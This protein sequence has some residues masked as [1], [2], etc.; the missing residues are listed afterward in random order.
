MKIRNSP[1][2]VILVSTTLFFA[3]CNQS[4]NTAHGDISTDSVTIAKGENIFNQNCIACHS[5][6]HD[7]IGP[8]LAGVTREV[9]ATWLEKFIKDPK[10]VIESG[11]TRAKALFD[12]YKSIM[13]SFAYYKDDEIDGIIAYLHTQAG[14]DRR[15]VSSADGQALKNPIPEGI[16]MSDLVVDMKEFVQMPATA[17]Q[18]PLTRITKFFQRPETKDFYVLDLRGKLYRLRDGKAEVFLNIADHKPN[19]INAP[20]HATGFGSFAF[21]PEFASNGLLY[22]TH[23]EA[24]GSAQADFFYEDSLKVKLQWVLSEWKTEKPG[25]FPYVGKSRELLRINMV[26]QSHGVQEIVFNPLAKRG[27]EDYGLLYIGV[28]DGGSA[29]R[30]ILHINKGP[31]NI[32]S[33]ILR[34]DPAGR[35]SANGKYGIP[36]SNPFAN[37]DNPKALGEVYAYGFRNPHKITWTSSGKMLASNIGQH[38]IEELNLILPGHDYGWP[39]R[40][41]RFVIDLKDN[42]RKLYPLSAD[43]GSLKLDYSVAEYDHDEGNAIIGGYEYQGSAIPELKGKYIFGDMVNGR[44]FYVN[45][46]DVKPGAKA[47]MKEFQISLNGK[48]TTFKAL[49]N[50]ERLSMRFGRDAD[51]EIYISTMPDGMVYKLVKAQQGGAI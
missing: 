31:E 38:N 28:G 8:A 3:A 47:P 20:G 34:I 43:D 6:S 39:T 51:G 17:E 25:S 22:T 46:D 30:G 9:S 5:M 24:A 7:G 27:D 33:S 11:D 32:W 13:P 37:S 36:A 23:T 41:G 19:F 40:E 50:D 49:C 2:S 12:K 21:H 14:V 26:G 18:R 1:L 4:P 29:E 16:P 44:L 15:M 45:V 42:T 35:N 48:R 10:G